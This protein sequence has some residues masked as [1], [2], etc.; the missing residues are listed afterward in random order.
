MD[1]IIQLT[2]LGPDWF[3]GVVDGIGYYGDL[4]YFKQLAAGKCELENTIPLAEDEFTVVEDGGI[5]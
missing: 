2:E 3:F 5:I 4:Y 1:T